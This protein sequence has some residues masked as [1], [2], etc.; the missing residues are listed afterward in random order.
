MQ[1]ND[2]LSPLR[3][4]Q[5]KCTAAHRCDY[6]TVQGSAQSCRY[7]HTRM[8]LSPGTCGLIAAVADAATEGHAKTRHLGRIVQTRVNYEARQATARLSES[9]LQV[10]AIRSVAIKL[11]RS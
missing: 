6:S 11:A 3:R 9:E 4:S 1:S 10:R 7:A 2:P 5:D 8:G